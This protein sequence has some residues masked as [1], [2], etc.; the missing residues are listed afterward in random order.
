MSVSLETSGLDKK[1]RI[2]IIASV[3]VVVVLLAMGCAIGVLD[4]RKGYRRRKQRASQN[5]DSESAM[6]ES[7]MRRVSTTTQTPGRR[8]REHGLWDHLKNPQSSE[9]AGDARN[10]RQSVDVESGSAER[11]ENMSEVQQERIV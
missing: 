7:Q 6:L 5:R 3:V 2:G 4:C 10:I 9:I 11:V 8:K 1:T